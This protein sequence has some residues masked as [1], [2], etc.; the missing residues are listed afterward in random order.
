[1]LNIPRSVYN[2]LNI[3]ASDNLLNLELNIISAA[4][5]RDVK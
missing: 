4:I 1:M 3:C 5:D 2:V